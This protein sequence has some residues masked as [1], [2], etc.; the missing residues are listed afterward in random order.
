[1]VRR[2]MARARWRGVPSSLASPA[3]ARARVRSSSGRPVTVAATPIAATATDT[4]TPSL[5]SRSR[6][7][8]R[9]ATSPGIWRNAHRRSRQPTAPE[10]RATTRV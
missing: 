7:P 5:P 3:G 8:L 2:S 1:M 6:A 9:E 4:P 10:L